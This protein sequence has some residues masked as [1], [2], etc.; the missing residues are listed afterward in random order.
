MVTFSG[1]T[2]GDF[3]LEI[4]G[5]LFMVFST[6]T[7]LSTSTLLFFFVSFGGEGRLALEDELL[8]DPSYNRTDER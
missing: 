5:I 4:F 3:D 8:E 7:G 1:D 2:E 6:L